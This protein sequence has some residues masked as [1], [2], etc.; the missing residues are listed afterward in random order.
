M[1]SHNLLVALFLLAIA[2]SVLAYD[3]SPL[4]DFC[5]GDPNSPVF[6]NGLVCKNP[7][8]VNNK[9]FIFMGMFNRPG[10]TS[11]RLGS[12][13]TPAF[14]TQFPALNTMGVSLVRIDFAPGGINPLHTHPRASEILVCVQGTL[15]VG[16]VTSNPENRFFSNVLYP[17]DLTVFPKGLIHFQ[18]NI[19][20]VPAV[21]F[22]G[23]GSQNPGVITIA[24]AV[25]NSTPPLPD[26]VLQRS[27]GVG[28]EVVNELRAP[29]GAV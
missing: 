18:L 13:V 1:G 3:P 15:L 16:F 14:V 27:F 29:F 6:V 10:N 28:Q 4:Q 20:R 8:L 7:A 19:G 9:D 22:A 23:L 26:I 24:N 25:F 11:N 17:G 21:A 5:V 2:S 12:A